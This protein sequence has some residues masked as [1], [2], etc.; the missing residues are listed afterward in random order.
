[1]VLVSS[2]KKQFVLTAKLTARR[3]AVI[4][5]Y[6]P[7]IDALYDA[8]EETTQAVK[9]FP[10]EWTEQN[11]VAFARNLVDSVL[12]RPVQDDDDIFQHGCDRSDLSSFDWGPSH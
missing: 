1:M 2:P 7:E 4:N 8:V 9:Y 10:S 11:S 3:Q 12:Q 6:E 5:Q